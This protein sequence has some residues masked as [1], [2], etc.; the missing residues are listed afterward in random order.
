MAEAVDLFGP[1]RKSIFQGGALQRIPAAVVGGALGAYAGRKSGSQ[2][3][4]TPEGLLLGSGVGTLFFSPA[5]MRTY[6]KY[7]LKAG[8]LNKALAP[9][10]VG[11]GQKLLEASSPWESL[12][13]TP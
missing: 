12:G 6:I 4:G 1:G 9:L 11:G 5:A 3:F 8:K 10:R 13:V 2:D 7:G